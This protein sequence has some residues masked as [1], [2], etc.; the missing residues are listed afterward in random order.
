MSN[1]YMEMVWF[2]TGGRW[3]GRGTSVAL[4]VRDVLSHICTYTHW[5]LEVNYCSQVETWPPGLAAGPV[6]TKSTVCV[7]VPPPHTHTHTV[8]SC[9]LSPLGHSPLS[10]CCKFHW[11]LETQTCPCP[12]QTNIFLAAQFLNVIL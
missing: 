7:F 10:S 6:L 11:K 8:Y 12:K 3:G 1:L 4:G 2:G 9:S 5:A